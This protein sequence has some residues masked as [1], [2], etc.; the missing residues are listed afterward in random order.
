M[1]DVD[2]YVSL[3]AC[4]GVGK[5][6]DDLV[7]TTAGR[8]Q[9]AMSL[10]LRIV[11]DPQV[12]VVDRLIVFPNACICLQILLHTTVDHQFQALCSI[13]QK[14]GTNTTMRCAAV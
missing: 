2:Y 9:P 5:V 10:E 11:G 12:A 4:S 6:A 14:K 8:P 3:C 7:D 13:R 1:N